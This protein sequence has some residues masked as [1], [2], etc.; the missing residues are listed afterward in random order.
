V[1]LFDA[2]ELRRESAKKAG[3]SGSDQETKD[4][5]DQREKKRFRE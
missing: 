2:R 4:R 5:A 3:C 1:N